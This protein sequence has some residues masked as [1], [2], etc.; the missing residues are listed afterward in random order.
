MEMHAFAVL[1]M[2]ERAF[3]ILLR[4]SARS[5]ASSLHLDQLLM[6]LTAST[7]T[8]LHAFANI[9]MTSDM[10]TLA[11]VV[12]RF[13]MATANLMTV[14]ILS[15]WSIAYALKPS[16]LELMMFIVFAPTLTTKFAIISI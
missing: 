12:T 9:L 4:S 11:T 5:L 6:L 1:L 16:F 8:S 7:S 3:M 10:R 15:T 2:T 14:L 13:A